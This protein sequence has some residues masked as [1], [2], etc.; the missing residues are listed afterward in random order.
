M[1][2]KCP[3]STPKC[4]WGCLMAILVAG[5]LFLQG[6]GGGGGGINITVDGPPLSDID[7][8]SVEVSDM[9]VT[10]QDG[11]L[12]RVSVSCRP[13]G[14]CEEANIGGKTIVVDAS[15]TNEEGNVTFYNTLGNWNDTEAG[16]VYQR[17][18]GDAARYA[19]AAGIVYPNSLPA[20]GSATW[21]GDM[22]GLDA[23]NRRVR[24]EAVLTI[25]DLSNPQV[26]VTLKP[27]AHSVMQW[28]NLPVVSGRF[29][30]KRRV[31]DYIRGEFY[32]QRAQETGGVFEKNGIVGAFGAVEQ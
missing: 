11:S 15:E 13:S 24:G 1:K 2:K 10:L 22:V 21:S 29:S 16:A 28:N 6:C 20:Q 7:A 27:Q 18:D 9:L 4:N 32:G 31:D 23:N 8:N 12:D 19:I 17:L 26:D 30:Q 5:V 3:N 14:I 25:S